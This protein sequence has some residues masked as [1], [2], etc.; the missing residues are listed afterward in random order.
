[1]ILFV[2]TLTGCV[3]TAEIY[4]EF[5]KNKLSIEN[6]S[7]LVDV[8]VLEDI[9]GNIDKTDVIINKELGKNFIKEFAS[10]LHDKGYEVNEFYLFSGMQTDKQ[11][12]YRVVK[13]AEEQQLGNDAI[14]IDKPPFY[15]DERLNE[16]KGTLISI[17]DALKNQ[18]P[19]KK[20]ES[21]KIIRDVTLLGNNIHWDT[22]ILIS[23]EARNV[24][25]EKQ[26]G[27]A[28][29]TSLLTLGTVA[30]WQV[31][32]ANA[33]L[34]ILK[35]NGEVIW[36]SQQFIKGGMIDERFLKNLA[37]GLVNSVPDKFPKI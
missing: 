34:F 1:L 17:F 19:K 9:T 22:L 20:G 16:N 7:L 23:L 33:T 26:I 27:Q 31:S 37:T 24:P 28:V 18:P 36:E 13:S 21:N 29:L 14:P 12:T 11:Q 6:V 30:T 32:T 10:I 2:T 3:T 15:I 5:S 25:I 8:V 35:N 4:P